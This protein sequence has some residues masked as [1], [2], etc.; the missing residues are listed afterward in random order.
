M[1]YA[2]ITLGGK[3]YRVQEGERLLVDRLKTDEGKT[4]NPKVLLIGGNGKTDLAPTIAVTARVVS[5]ELGE[6]I[7]IGKYKKR[8][9]YRKHTGFRASLTQIEIESIGAGARKAAAAKPK[10]DDKPKA[11]EKPKATAPAEAPART[12][13][14]PKGYEEMTVAEIAAEAAGWRRPNLEA[15][16]EYEHANAKRKGAIAA[17]ESALAEKESH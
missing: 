9:G 7:R 1:S 16:L 13:H 6:K 14:P 15:A 8:T 2:I 10:A 17:L 12:A 3:Q 11:E 5:H 4:F